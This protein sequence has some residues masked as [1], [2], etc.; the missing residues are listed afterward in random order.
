ML[1]TSQLLWMIIIQHF[2]R[3]VFGTLL[4]FYVFL[5]KKKIESSENFFK[6]I[7]SS[8]KTFQV[9]GKH[10]KFT[11]IKVELWSFFLLDF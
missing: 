6:N 5:L 3:Y 9:H 10:F 11:K 4:E 8:R 7:L 2:Q 1:V